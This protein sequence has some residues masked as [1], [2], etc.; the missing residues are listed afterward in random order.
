MRTTTRVLVATIAAAASVLTSAG[1]STAGGVTSVLVVSADRERAAAAY[2]S[3]PAFDRLAAAVGRDEDIPSGSEP[4]HPRRLVVWP[5]GPQITVSWMSHDVSPHR[6]DQVLL[7]VAG[8]PWIRTL[9]AEAD[10]DVYCATGI[11]HRPSDPDALRA[12]LADLDVAG[13][14][15]PSQPTPLPPNRPGDDVDRNDRNGCGDADA[16]SAVET[17]SEETLAARPSG[18][19]S[20]G[21]GGPRPVVVWGLG[22]LLVGLVAGAGGRPAFERVVAARSRTRSP[23]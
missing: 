7:D 13:A 20:E 6:I 17:P 18:G 16:P 15:P 3:E 22:A 1:P 11:W 2:S 10:R 12:A 8:G 5:S 19:G 14:D 9:R 21:S 23:S 4:G